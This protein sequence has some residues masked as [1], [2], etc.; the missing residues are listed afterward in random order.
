MDDDVN[1]YF[2]LAPFAERRWHLYIPSTAEA[3]SAHRLTLTGWPGAVYYSLIFVTIASK[4][5]NPAM[6][7]HRIDGGTP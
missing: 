5:P 3:G 2:D 1:D 6:N 7:R 4:W